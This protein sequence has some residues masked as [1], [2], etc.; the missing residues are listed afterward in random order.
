MEAE[1][2]Q[3]ELGRIRLQRTKGRHDR[4]TADVYE[5]DVV[6]EPAAPTEGELTVPH[7]Q[8]DRAFVD[9]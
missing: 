1:L 4:Y 7:P 5:K 9:V 3:T 6:Q 2:A 8:A